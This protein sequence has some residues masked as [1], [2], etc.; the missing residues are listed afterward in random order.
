MKIVQFFGGKYKSIHFLLLLR[1]CVTW[2][3]FYK[4]TEAQTSHRPGNLLKLSAE[5]PR[6]SKASH[7]I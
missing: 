7:E 6:C 2:P 5:T 4:N 1:V 3:S